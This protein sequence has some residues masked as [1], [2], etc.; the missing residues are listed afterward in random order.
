V[1]VQRHKRLYATLFDRDSVAV[2][3]L[4]PTSP[5]FHQVIAEV[6]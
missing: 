2:V 1:D 6:P 4:D 3:D 5:S